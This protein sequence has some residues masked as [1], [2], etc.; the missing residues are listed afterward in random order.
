MTSGTRKPP[1]IST[2]SPR[3]TGTA[4]PAA[5]AAS[6][7]STAAALLLTIIAASAPHSLA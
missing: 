5:R 2:L 4:R 7:S 6:T 3:L 1:P